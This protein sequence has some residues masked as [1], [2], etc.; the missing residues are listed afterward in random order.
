VPARLLLVNW[1]EASPK[2]YS[3]NVRHLRCPCNTPNYHDLN[4]GG[5]AFEVCRLEG[6]R[7]RSMWQGPTLFI[8]RNSHWFQPP[9]AAC[10]EPLP[11]DWAACRACPCR[12]RRWP[13]WDLEG[14][15]ASL[16][17]APAASTTCWRGT[18]GARWLQGSAQEDLGDLKLGMSV[19]DEDEVEH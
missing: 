11:Q 12:A 4:E 7:T 19:E 8:P 17:V 16:T 5:P 6:R 2:R 15:A 1:V 3:Y 10:A 14:G 13:Q 18:Q 9:V